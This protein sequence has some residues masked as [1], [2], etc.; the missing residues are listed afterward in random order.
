ML[1]KDMKQKAEAAGKAAVDDFVGINQKQ[2]DAILEAQKDFT[3]CCEQAVRGWA[4]RIKL[5]FDLASDL[6]TKLRGAKSV[7]DSIHVYQEWLG[8][9][10]KLSSEESQEFMGDFQRLLDASTRAMSTSLH[11]KA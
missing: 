8:H 10:I 7:P 2:M 4:D 5:E 1:D 6:T 3:A 9:R 11:A